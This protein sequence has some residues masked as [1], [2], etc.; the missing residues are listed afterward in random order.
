[1]SLLNLIEDYRSCVDE[2]VELLVDKFGDLYFLQEVNQG[3]IPRELEI[4]DR[5][6]F[7]HGVGCSVDGPDLEV[8]FDFGP[9]GRH[10]G[11][12]AWRLY[13]FASAAPEKY[14]S[15]SDKKNIEEAFQKLVDD[16]VIFCPKDDLS[17]HLYYF[18]KASERTP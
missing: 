15:L 5:T 12:D 16:G 6:Y 18:S 17:P 3:R 13:L 2:C 9:N 10:D 7:F 14:P 11:F 4:L 1:M 8:N